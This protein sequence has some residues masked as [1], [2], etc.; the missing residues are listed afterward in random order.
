MVSGPILGVFAHPDDEATACG[1]TFSRYSP[2]G[3]E[4][5]VVTATRGE[6]GTLGTGGLVIPREELPQVRQREQQEV[7]KLLGV[8]RVL[9]LDYTDGEM[10]DALQEEVMEKVLRVMEQLRPEVVITFGPQGI[11]RHG[12]HVAVSRAA[13]EAFH[14]YR[15]ASGLTR[16]PSLYYVAIPK[17]FVEQFAMELDGVETQPTTVIDIA[18][19][20]ALKIQAIRSY[21]SQEDAQQV[22]KMF[23]EM[24]TAGSE[25]YHQ[26]YPPVDDGSVKTGF[27]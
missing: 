2:E 27:W 25:Y 24:P 11:S 14:R 7:A 10:Q 20:K 18:Q 26:A 13:T 6:R 8:R 23:E 4:I 9:Y 3:V 15:Q 16:E 19:Q 17:E 21:R 22:A 12:D 1:G 5:W